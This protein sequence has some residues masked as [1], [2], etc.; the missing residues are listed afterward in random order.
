[1]AV[2]NGIFLYIS[3]HYTLRAKTEDFLWRNICG[4]ELIVRVSIEKVKELRRPIID[5][6]LKSVAFVKS[7]DEININHSCYTKRHSD[8]VV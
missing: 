4:L 6:D 1:M 7:W 8:N 3:T 2:T 5:T